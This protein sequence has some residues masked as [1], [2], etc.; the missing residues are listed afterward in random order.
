[1]VTG[2]HPVEVED[3]VVSV[4]DRCVSSLPELVVE[5]GACVALVG[6]SGSGKSSAL[7]AILGLSA[8][9]GARARGRV[10]LFGV[11]PLSASSRE[12]RRVRGLRAAFVAQTPQG[13]LNPTMRLG[14]LLKRSLALHGIA[15]AEA[16]TRTSEAM[17][18]VLLPR[19]ILD[20]YPH[21][22]SGGQAQR[23]AIAL[24]LALG[25]ELIVADEPT[26]AL[27]VTVQS[28][29]LA[30][31]LRLRETKELSL[32][33]VSHDLAVVST[34]ADRIVVMR[35]GAVVESAQ[36]SELFTNPSC[37]YTRELI[38]AVPAFGV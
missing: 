35:E 5:R 34:L 36:A 29:I 12:L 17:S 11:D 3:L 38:D 22:I 37:D 30:L 6:E 19:H 15:G 28:E 18:G 10:R 7:L 4:R 32:L 16:E 20:R 25:A 27:D 13:A 31:L 14:A 24:A 8:S 1:M 33:L 9:M 2:A 23:F 21:E 26:S